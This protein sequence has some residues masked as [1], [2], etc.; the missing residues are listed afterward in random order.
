MVGAAA[1][2]WWTAGILLGRQNAAFHSPG[3]LASVHQTWESKCAACHADFRAIRDDAVA[4]SWQ[5]GTPASDQKCQACHRGAEHHL[6]AKG[7]VAPGCS[8]CHQDHQGRDA[9]LL[10]VADAACTNCHQDIKRHIDGKPQSMSAPVNVTVF[11]QQHHPE[12]TSAQKDPGHLKFSHYRHLTPGL[13]NNPGEEKTIW[14]LARISDPAQRERYRRPGQS[15]DSPV[16]LNCGSCHQL[17]GGDFGVPRVAGASPSASPPRPAGDYMLPIIYENQCQACHPLYKSPGIVQHRKTTEEIRV[18]LRRAIAQEYL[19]GSPELLAQFIPP[20]PLP[21]ARPAEDEKVARRM[22]DKLEIAEKMLAQEYCGK[23]HEAAS[24][25]PRLQPVVPTEVPQVWFQHASFSHRAHR[26]MD[27]R[28]CHASAYADAPNASRQ[29]KDVLIP[30]RDVCLKCH[31]P[32]SPAGFATTGPATTGGARFD[33]VECHRYHNGSAP[34]AGSGAKAG[35][36]VRKL[37]EEEFEAGR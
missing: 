35:S 5:G 20:E 27:C 32:P 13:V 3:A 6:L 28:Q 36:P 1:A 34:L 18:E 26:A 30:G 11:D 4:T 23:C 16:Q 29:S 21:N 15:D 31:S 25:G 2:A 10:R 17:D 22:H 14:T 24:P 33:C 12:F 19:D 9:S 37:T 7:T 8:S